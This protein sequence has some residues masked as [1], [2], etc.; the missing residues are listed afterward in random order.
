MGAPDG[1]QD[2]IK[3]KRGVHKG[4][5]PD[6]TTTFELLVDPGMHQ[7]RDVRDPEYLTVYF[8]AAEAVFRQVLF[9]Q[10]QEGEVRQIAENSLKPAV[11]CHELSYPRILEFIDIEREHRDVL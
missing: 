8:Q 5:P 9:F 7:A 4:P 2:L 11:F 6:R 10:S 3:Q 1:V